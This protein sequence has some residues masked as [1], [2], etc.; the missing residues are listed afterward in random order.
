VIEI[1]YPFVLVFLL[2]LPLASCHTTDYANSSHPGPLAPGAAI[3]LK[4]ELQVPPGLA[5]VYLQYG[6]AVRYEFVD[7]YA[8]FCYFRMRAPLPVVQTVAPGVLRVDSVTSEETEVRKSLPVRTAARTVLASD[9]GRGPIAYRS[10]MRLSAPGQP[11]IQSLVCSGAFDTPFEA[12]P[13]SFPELLQVFGDIAEFRESADRP[14][15]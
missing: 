8:P 12:E 3:V 6:R 14:V 4:R 5:R 10:H 7:Q 2:V 1:R 15:Q 11:D 9:A 13:I